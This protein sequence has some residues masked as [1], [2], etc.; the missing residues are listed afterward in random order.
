MEELSPWEDI[1]KRAERRNEFSIKDVIQQSWEIYKPQAFAFSGFTILIFCAFLFLIPLFGQIGYIIANFIVVPCLL[2]GFATFTR[3]IKESA[4]PRGNGSAL[5]DGFTQM[6]SIGLV[7]MA[8]NLLFTASLAP[9]IIILNNAGLGEILAE[10]QQAVLAQETIDGI[11][12]SLELSLINK[13]LIFANIIFAIYLMVCF[14]W[15][16]LL[17]F[18][19]KVPFYQGI[20]G[21][22]KLISPIWWKIFKLFVTLWLFYILASFGI[23]MLSSLLGPIFAF[24]TTI[25]MVVGLLI[26]I[27]ISFISSYLIFDLVFE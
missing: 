10:I 8:T 5:F 6:L 14:L 7:A 1:L 25:G 17:V 16:P 2:V 12:F 23:S 27:P 4:D 21:S 26:V 22:R 3:V 20:E 18:F 19:K 24:F 9:T 15:A 13:I 11:N